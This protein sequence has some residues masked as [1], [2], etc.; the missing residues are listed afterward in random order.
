MCG[1]SARG[2]QMLGVSHGLAIG[3]GI[4]TVENRAQADDRL[5]GKK[6]HKGEEVAECALRM[7]EIKQQFGVA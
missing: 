3:Y 5:G 4:L 2:L 7:I 6:G 1:E